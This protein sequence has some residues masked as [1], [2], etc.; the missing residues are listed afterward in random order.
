M[1]PRA[2]LLYYSYTGQAQKVLRA[3]GAVLTAR[4]FE[5]SLSKEPSENPWVRYLLNP[6]SVSGS[7]R[8][9]S[10]LQPTQRDTTTTAT[11]S[12]GWSLPLEG[13]GAINLGHN[14]RAQLVPNAL[15]ASVNGTSND[16][17]RYT[18]SDLSKPFKLAPST[19]RNTAGLNMGAGFRPL[20]LVTYRIDSNRDLML[21]D[22]QQRIAGLGLG[23][24]VA[25]THNLTANYDFP[26][27]RRSLAPK[28]SWT[29]RSRSRKWRCSRT[30]NSISSPT[31]SAPALSNE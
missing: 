11:G 2:L 8:R 31:V 9:T 24:E 23:R 15:S 20:Q 12:V 25:R 3:A 21:R 19:S 7:H 6:F 17:R 30:I 1:K 28:V 13:V 27:F 22:G 26:L 18:R 14:W 4:G 10:S 16:Q 5:V 29:G